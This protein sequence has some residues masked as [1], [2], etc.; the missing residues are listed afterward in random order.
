MTVNMGTIWDR[1]TRFLGDN[2]RAALPVVTLAILLPQ[3]VGGIVQLGAASIGQPAA[4]G[5]GLILTLIALWG[6]LF[7]IAFALR[8][9]AGTQAAGTVATGGYGRALLVMLVLFV[10]LLLLLVPPAIVLAG[11]GVD[12]AQLASGQPPATEPDISIGAGL[13][14]GLYTIALLIVALFVMARFTP[15]YAVLLAERRGLGAI[16]RSIAITRGLTWKLVGVWLLFLLVFVVA[17]AAARSVLGVIVGLIFS[18]D[19]VFSPAAVVGAIAA[20]LVTTG[21]TV[22]VAAFSAN[23]YRAVVPAPVGAADPA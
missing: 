4:Q 17:S 21:F 14:L 1:T 5:I 19:A 16:G 10:V 6:Q 7:L 23:L 11:S 9:E 20:A 2:L 15:L 18:S 12:L 8:P 22:I 3:A 13:F